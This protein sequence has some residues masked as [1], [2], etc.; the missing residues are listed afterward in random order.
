MSDYS[1][2]ELLIT[3][4]AEAWRHDGEVLATG[5][6]PLARLG[7]FL[8]KASF[9]PHL[10]LTDGECWYVSTPVSLGA[11]GDMPVDVEGWAPYE[12]VFSCLWG[13]R[14]HAMVTPVQIDRY[15][16]VNISLIGDHAK[17]KVAMLGARG[18]PGNSIHHPNS[19]FFQQHSTRTFVAGEVDYVCA[20]GYNPARWPGARYP[21]GLELRRIVTDL[22]VMDFGGPGHQ[23]RVISLHP[24][25]SFDQVQDN[26]GFPLARI[27]TL[28]TTPAPTAE[29]LTLIARLDPGHVRNTVFKGDP[30]GDRR[31]AL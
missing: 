15:G 17:P 5:F 18:L 2:A 9:N 26:T 1:L 27:D 21:A 24:G 7:T 29:Q 16:Q 11:Q 8:A 19:F 22:C 14:R 13:G 6:G 10:A 3:A 31:A 23:I 25:V 28:S 4:S 20:A 12:R 30:P